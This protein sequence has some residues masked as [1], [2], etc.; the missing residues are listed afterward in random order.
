MKIGVYSATTPTP[1]SAPAASPTTTPA[2]TASTTPSPSVSPRTTPTVAPTATTVPV[3]KDT[4]D[5]FVNQTTKNRLTEAEV[6]A[7]MTKPGL[8]ETFFRLDEEKQK[9]LMEKIL[10]ADKE[11][12]VTKKLEGLVSEFDT[13]TNTWKS[14]TLM[15]IPLPNPVIAK[16]A[17][18]GFSSNEGLKLAELYI[19]IKPNLSTVV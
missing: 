15:S 7:F 16:L 4:I 8:K 12:Y 11:K 3:T 5:D 10:I 14:F 19:A 9:T 13:K 18:V 1:S 6:I 17:F 2:P